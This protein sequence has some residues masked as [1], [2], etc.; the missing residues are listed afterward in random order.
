M[1]STIKIDWFTGVAKNARQH[2]FPLKSFEYT[3]VHHKGWS[4]YDVGERELDTDIKRYSSTTR[5]DMGYGI[6]ASGS[7]LAKLAE[8]PHGEGVLTEMFRTGLREY[9]ASRLDLAVDLHDGGELAM[10]V[11]RAAK[12]DVIRTAARQVSTI[13]GVKG[14]KG[15][16][17]Y[18]GSRAST[19]FMRI[20]DKNAESKGKVPTS[21][22]ELQCNKRFAAQVWRQITHPTQD[23]LN[24]ST[25]AAINGFVSDWGDEAVNTEMQFIGSCKPAPA[26]EPKEDRWEWLEKQ[27]LPT[28]LRDYY[29]ADKPDES[30]LAR[31]EKAIKRPA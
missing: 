11:A 8:N 6:V 4:G 14:K 31:L 19:R 20:Y 25:M 23:M 2:P 9:R 18:I 1:L 7:A 5:P 3:F 27:V 21:R 24:G 13:E 22:F 15:L 10:K 29:L 26:P 28:L 12:R 17:T 30:L 16:T